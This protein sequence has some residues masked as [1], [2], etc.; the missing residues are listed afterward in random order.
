MVE[1]NTFESREI[2]V[3]REHFYLLRHSIKDNVTLRELGLS[4]EYDCEKSIPKY[5]VHLKGE[6]ESIEEFHFIYFKSKQVK[7]Q[8]LVFFEIE[9]DEI[10]CVADAENSYRLNS[11]FLVLSELYNKYAFIPKN[12]ILNQDFNNSVILFEIFNDDQTEKKIKIRIPENF[13]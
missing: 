13:N 11:S 3:S 12:Q 7:S 10:N 4:V 9:D 1:T 5:S 2:E 8:K 6:R